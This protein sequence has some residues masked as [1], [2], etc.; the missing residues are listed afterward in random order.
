VLFCKSVLAR[1][2][3][4]ASEIEVDRERLEQPLGWN[5]GAWHELLERHGDGER[6]V[7]DVATARPEARNGAGTY[8]TVPTATTPAR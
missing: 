6:A 5:Q 1:V 3:A 8:E 7:I 4:V 2:W